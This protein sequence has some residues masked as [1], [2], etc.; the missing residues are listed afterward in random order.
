MFL[1]WWNT[2][3]S[4]SNIWQCFSCLLNKKKQVLMLAFWKTFSNFGKT[5]YGISP[6]Q[7]HTVSYFSQ[8]C[9]PIWSLYNVLQ[10]AYVQVTYMSCHL[11]RI[12][13]NL[14]TWQQSTTGLIVTLRLFARR[15]PWPK[16][17]WKWV[18]PEPMSFVLDLRLLNCRDIVPHLQIFLSTGKLYLNFCLVAPF[19]LVFLSFC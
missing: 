13:K 11:F 5:F 10:S 7:N 19:F 17:W 6:L 8:I 12:N 9:L 16:I 3:K 15:R 18:N 4:L 14:R 1:E 2:I